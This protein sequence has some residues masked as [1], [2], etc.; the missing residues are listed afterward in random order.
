MISII[1]ALIYVVGLFVSIAIQTY[2]GLSK[3]LKTTGDIFF[4]ETPIEFLSCL[5]WPIGLPCML[6]VL[7]GKRIF[8]RSLLKE[9]E[10][11]K[12]LYSYRG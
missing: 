1:I 10:K 5:F 9:M 2:V 8:H 12:N 3:G 11:E 4:G 6:G 7:L